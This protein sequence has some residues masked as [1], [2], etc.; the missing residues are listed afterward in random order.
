MVSLNLVAA[1]RGKYLDPIFG[2]HAFGYSPQ[3]E[4]GRHHDDRLYDLRGRFIRR[5]PVNPFLR[6]LEI[7]DVKFLQVTQ[8]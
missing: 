4:C 5:N 6:Y 2:F 7:L 1:Q 8:G 3:S